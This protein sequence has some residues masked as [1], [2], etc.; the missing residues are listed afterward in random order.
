MVARVEP[1]QRQQFYQRHLRGETYEQIAECFAVSKECVRYWCRRQR[2]GGS[3]HTRC[4]H[5]KPGLLASFDALVRY[6]IL[7]LRLH[8]PRWGPSR[9][10]AHLRQRPSLYHRALP[11]E[12]SIGRY[13]HRKRSAVALPL[14]STSQT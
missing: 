8:H 3:P 11:S 6:V 2:D 5:R 12:A 9:I 4:G 7:Y 1:H 10:L 14:D 13:L